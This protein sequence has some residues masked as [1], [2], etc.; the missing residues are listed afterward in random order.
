MNSERIQG[1]QQRMVERSIMPGIVASWVLTMLVAVFSWL[2]APEYR[3]AAL[4]WGAYSCFVFLLYL[5]VWPWYL[6]QNWSVAQKEK[7]LIGM[8]IPHALMWSAM[9]LMLFADGQREVSMVLMLIFAGTSCGGVPL[10]GARKGTYWVM[11]VLPFLVQVFVFLRY[12]L[13]HAFDPF[14]A[15]LGIS[16]FTLLITN[17]FAI[18]SQSETIERSIRLG[19]ENEDLVGQ[20]R[21]Q[22]DQLHQQAEL[23]RQQ[24]QAANE[25]NQAKTKFLAAA[26]HDLRQPA[27]ALN[28]FVEALNQTSLD[29]EQQGIV[30]HIQAANQASRD[31]LNTLLDF[32][33]I[34]AGVMEA[35]PQPTPLAPLLLALEEEFGPQADAKNLVYRSHETH[36]VAHCDASLVALVLRNFVSNAIRY[37]Q[38]GG[39]LIAVRSRGQELC[40][41]VW[42]TGI[43]IAAEQHEVIFK[44]FHQ[45]GNEERDRQK[46]LGAGLG[47][48]A[49]LG[50]DDGRTSCLEIAARARLGV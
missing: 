45:L 9:S 32:S 8:M 50:H 42:D 35:K 4:V 19:F 36:A 24:T 3:T 38:R 25:A 6:R 49:R 27:H 46:G 26:S 12:S 10:L 22:T 17:L 33:R 11:M 13:T 37:T 34:E 29:A 30:G 23:L 39:V 43:G 20:L 1:M 16:M 47:D 5:L 28:L 44:E 15:V 18:Q 48:C 2:Q 21:E 7:F 14:H 31:M 41:Q 40:L